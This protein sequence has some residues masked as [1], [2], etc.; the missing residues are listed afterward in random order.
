MNIG[1][2]V[3]GYVV[4]DDV[5]DAIHIETA[6]GNVGRHQNVKLALLEL[7]NRAFALGLGDIAIECRRCESPGRQFLGQLH[8]QQARTHKHDHAIEGFRLQDA[9]QRVQLVHTTDRPDSLPDQVGGRLLYG[10]GHFRRV[11][12]MTVRDATNFGWHGCREQSD[13]SC[14]RRL[15]Q[16]PLHILN[17]S[18][19]QH[20]VGLIEHQRRQ[21]LQLQCALADVIHHPAGRTNHHVHAA[22][23][24]A[25]LATVILAAVHWQYMEAL[26]VT[27]VSLKRLGHLYR[28]FPGWR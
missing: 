7:V 2:N 1:F 11:I 17:E 14:R 16:N 3:I 27:G 5:A 21:L 23:E 8:C 18:H 10:N 19:A 24:R 4:V 28:Q 12:Q 6:G 20:L 13:L 25:N 9:R 26:D 22:R 15:L